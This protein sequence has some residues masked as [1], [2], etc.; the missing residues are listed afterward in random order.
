[1]PEM[2]QCLAE[3]EAHHRPT[4]WRSLPLA[5]WS[6]LIQYR[7]MIRINIH[8]AKAHLSRYLPLIERG[9]TI[10]LCKRN[11]PIAE[12]RPITP[13]RDDPRPVGLHRG[14]FSVPPGFFDPLPDDLRRAFEGE[15]REGGPDSAEGG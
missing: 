15:S 7:I 14:T 1:M 9:E 12:I 11:V 3:L 13:S 5:P 2:R 4:I 8:E 10:L 6:D